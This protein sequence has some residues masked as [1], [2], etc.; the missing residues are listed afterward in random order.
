MDDTGDLRTPG[1]FVVPG[2]DLSWAFSRSGGPGGQ[3]VNKTSS[4]VT[5]T[6]DTATITGDDASLERIRNTLSEVRVV[7]QTSRSQWR[8]RQL[9]LQRAAT[10]IDDAAKPPAAERHPSKP[11]RG[12]NERR[13][14]SK[15]R[16][17]AKKQS[18]RITNW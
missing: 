7:S 2:N 5:L 15:R 6:I 18:R 12:S 1:G 8:N 16:D 4:K 14:D 10:I 9:C 13:L 17:S 11:S 3:H